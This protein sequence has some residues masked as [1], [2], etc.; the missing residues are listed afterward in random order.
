MITELTREERDWGI[1]LHLSA[2]AMHIIPF[3]NILGPLIIWS[4][5]RDRSAYLDQQGREVLNFHISWT[6]GLVL[7]VLLQV[8][9]IASGIK[10]V[11]PLLIL[12][13]IGYYFGMLYFIVVAALRASDGLYFDY[14][15]LWETFK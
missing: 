8:I 3:G 1:A 12:T 4:S 2:L 6:V 10:I 5:K 15:V 9:A 7:A 14:P 11:I 13:G